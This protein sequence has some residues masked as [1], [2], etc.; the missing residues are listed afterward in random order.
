MLFLPACA[1]IGGET[2]YTERKGARGMKLAADRV[3]TPEEAVE[4]GLAD[5][6]ISFSEI[7]EG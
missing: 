6:I 4:F 2:K 7:M 1:I 5:R 3:L